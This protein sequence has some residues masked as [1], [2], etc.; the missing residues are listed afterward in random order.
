[1]LKW[2]KEAVCEVTNIW[3]NHWMKPQHV[4]SGAGI[5][6]LP[7]IMLIQFL[8]HRTSLTKI[9]E[10]TKDFQLHAPEISS[11]FE[12]CP[13]LTNCLLLTGTR[14][15][16]W[17]NSYVKENVIQRGKKKLSGQKFEIM[18]WFA[19]L[20]QLCYY[21]KKK[22][23]TILTRSMWQNSCLLSGYFFSLVWSSYQICGT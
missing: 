8:S 22:V 16:T 18:S 9:L 14:V 6:D 10:L 17:I 15:K 4:G 12:N 3:K 11:N 20:N 7:L 5:E 13:N 1:M 2:Q 21:Q 23:T 19:A